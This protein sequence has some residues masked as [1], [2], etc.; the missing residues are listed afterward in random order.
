MAY[1]HLN[2][3]L[4]G[5]PERA[6][7]ATSRTAESAQRNEADHNIVEGIRELCG[8]IASGESEAVLIYQDDATHEWFCK[9]GSIEGHG[10]TLRSA[11]RDAMKRA[12]IVIKG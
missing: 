6:H 7:H 5:V 11:V 1:D 8:N 9:A 3:A 10:Q 4:S 2:D 12:H